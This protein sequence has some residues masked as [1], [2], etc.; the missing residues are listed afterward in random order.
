MRFEDKAIDGPE[1]ELE[2]NRAGR[3]LEEEDDEEVAEI[4]IAEVLAV[5]ARERRCSRRCARSSST[6]TS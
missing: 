6:A 1:L 4:R 5:R 2:E 3:E